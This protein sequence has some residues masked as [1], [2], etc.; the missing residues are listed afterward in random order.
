MGSGWPVLAASSTVLLDAVAVPVVVRPV[1]DAVVVVVERGLFLAPEATGDGFLVHVVRNAVVVVVGVFTVGNAVV[2]V[3]HVVEGG[4]AEPLA[5]DT[6]VPDCLEVPVAVG[7]KVVAVVVVVHAVQ[8]AEEVRI[9]LAVV[10]VEVVVAVHF[11]VVPDAVVVVVHVKP[12]VDRV[13]IVVKIDRVVGEVAVGVAVDVVVVEVSAQLI[14]EVGLGAV[15]GLPLPEADQ[16]AKPG[17]VGVA[18]V[19]DVRVGNACAAA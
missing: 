7:V 19:H 16:Q 9:Q 17:D 13:V 5:Q 4:L 3:V 6:Q 12:I 8:S 11:E 2:V 1:G 18:V 10:V 14:G 15:V